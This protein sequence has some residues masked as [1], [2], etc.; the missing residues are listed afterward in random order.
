MLRWSILPKIEVW[1][2]INGETLEIIA[3]CSVKS[4]FKEEKI[5]VIILKHEMFFDH[6]VRIYMH[7]SDDIVSKFNGRGSMILCGERRFV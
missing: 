6:H 7:I 3:H 4:Y 2:H 5:G 1:I